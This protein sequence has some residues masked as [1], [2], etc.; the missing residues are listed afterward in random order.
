MLVCAASN[1]YA[2]VWNGSAFANSTT[3]TPSLPGTGRPDAGAYMLTN[4]RAIVAWGVN[5]SSTPQ[6]TTWNGSSWAA[7]A[8]LP[9]VSG[10]PGRIELAPCPKKNSNDVL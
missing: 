1:L 3:L 7:A 6:Y 10:T 5:G 9:T 8:S 2:A 4:G